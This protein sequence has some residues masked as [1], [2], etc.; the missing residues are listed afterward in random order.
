MH[1]LQATVVLHFTKFISVQFKKKPQR[2][3]L[4]VYQK[5]ATVVHMSNVL[6]FDKIFEAII[7]MHRKLDLR[8]EKNE[9]KTLKNN[10]QL[11]NGTGKKIT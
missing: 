2:I 5:V 6:Q 8:D 9:K 11:M 10:V 7:Q 3:L 1:K 4:D